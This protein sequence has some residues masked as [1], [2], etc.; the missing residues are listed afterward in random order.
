MRIDDV[1]FSEWVKIC[2]AYFDSHSRQRFS[3]VNFYIIIST[4]LLYSISFIRGEN[5]IYWIVIIAHIFE[6]VITF[7]FWRLECRSKFLIDN[8]ERVLKN[9]EKSF[10]TDQA[11]RDEFSLYS[12]EEGETGK[13]KNNRCCWVRHP[14][15]YRECFNLLFLCIAAYSIGVI[16]VVSCHL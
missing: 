5:P 4:A 13:Q 16:I 9:I 3:F 6:L 1:E 14:V 2:F 12:H 11:S 8:S 7:I 10:F 15:T